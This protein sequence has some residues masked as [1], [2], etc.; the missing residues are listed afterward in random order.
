MLQEQDAKL[1]LCYLLPFFIMTT[2]RT[3][4]EFILNA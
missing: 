1:A 4:I 3:S 2:V